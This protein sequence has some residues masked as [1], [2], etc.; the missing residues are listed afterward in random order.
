MIYFCPHHLAHGAGKLRAW[1]TTIKVDREPFSG[2]RV[3]GN[4]R[5][6]KDWV[7]SHRTIEPGVLPPVMWPTRLAMPTQDHEKERRSKW[8][9]VTLLLRGIHG[10]V[11]NTKSRT[12]TSRCGKLTIRNGQHHIQMNNYEGCTQTLI[13]SNIAQ[14]GRIGAI[15]FSERQT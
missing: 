9:I 5:W 6:R 13:V 1:A 14:N 10:A 15:T 8:R 11:S 2:P 12:Y 4:T 7:K 3:F